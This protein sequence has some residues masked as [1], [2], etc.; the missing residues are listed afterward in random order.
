MYHLLERVLTRR[1][2]YLLLSQLQ[3]G[4]FQLE[5][6]QREPEEGVS[7]ALPDAMRL[8]LSAFCLAKSDSQ[9]W[10]CRVTISSIMV[11]ACCPT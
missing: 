7:G 5:D 8:P 2:T 6:R 11:P 10:R 9:H 3:A 1:L 4:H